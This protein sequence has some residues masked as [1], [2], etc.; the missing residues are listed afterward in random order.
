MVRVPL[1][2]FAQVAL[3]LFSA[4]AVSTAPTAPAAPTP[5]LSKIVARIQQQSAFQS[6]ELESYDATRHYTIQYKGFDI[7]IAAQMA[8]QVHFD[9]AAGKSFRI[10]SQSGSKLLCDKV[11]KKA[12]ES[13]QEAARDKSAT[14]LSPANY[15]FAFNGTGV[16]NGRPNYILTV[17]PLRPGKFLYRGKVWI[18]ATDYQVARIEVEPAKNPSFWIAHSDI[19]NTYSPT[20]GVWLPEHNRS[21]SKIRIGG[22]AVLTIDYGKYHVVVNNRGARAANRIAQRGVLREAGF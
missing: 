18:D 8:V 14:A 5:S 11:L 9:Q 6:H 10:L 12:V 7:S 16:L 22:T 20:D 17:E 4:S 19:E 3:L 21:Q 2:A 13:E 15:R 1:W